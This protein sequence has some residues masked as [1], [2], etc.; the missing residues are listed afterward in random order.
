MCHS[1]FVVRDR[2]PE[3]PHPMVAAWWLITS[4]AVR[5][6]IAFESL[7]VRS[8]PRVLECSAWIGGS[9]I[10]GGGDDAAPIPASYGGLIGA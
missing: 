4:L 5:F 8:L 9:R 10:N 2:L 7:L 1:R 6:P 3:Y